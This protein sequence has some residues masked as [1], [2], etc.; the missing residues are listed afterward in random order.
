[1][2][3]KFGDL[4][5]YLVPKKRSLVTLLWFIVRRVL[6]SLAA[7]FGMGHVSAAL[8]VLYIGSIVALTLVLE[9]PYLDR[10]TWISQ[11]FNEVF[12]MLT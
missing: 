7:Y 1:M 10:A 5:G 8:P 12:L 3:G 6:F 11:L 2:L 4:Y 9:S